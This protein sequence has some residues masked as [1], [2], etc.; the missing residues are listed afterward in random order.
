MA[1][2]VYKWDIL[3]KVGQ[4]GAGTVNKLKRKGS[5]WARAW[6]IVIAQ[7]LHNNCTIIAHY[8]SL[9]CIKIKWSLAC[10]FRHL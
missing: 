2:I 1:E 3:E 7:L 8:A 4:T 6:F 9:I 10:S 5:Q